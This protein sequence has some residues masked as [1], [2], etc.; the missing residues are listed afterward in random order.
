MNDSN[1]TEGRAMRPADVLVPMIVARLR[2]LRRLGLIEPAE[3]QKAAAKKRRSTIRRAP[4]RKE[5]SK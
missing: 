1:E 2:E 3:G 5:P 4:K